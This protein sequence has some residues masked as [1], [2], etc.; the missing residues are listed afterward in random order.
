VRLD[1]QPVL[2]ALAALATDP[3]LSYR[4]RFHAP[5]SLADFAALRAA[6]PE[7]CILA[8]AT[9][10][11]LWVTKQFRDLGELIYLG[12]VAELKTIGAHDGVLSIGAAATLED[13]WQALAA[14]WPHLR[15]VGLR[16]AGPPV[17]H[18]GTMGGNVANGSPIGDSAPVLMALDARIV[19]QRADAV[20][21]MPLADFYVDYMKNR[22]EAGEFVHSLRVPLPRAG[23]QL[24][25][26]K[27]SKRFDCDISA[28]C[29]G[30]AITLDGDTVREARFAYGGMAAIVKRA[31][32]AEA[33]ARG[34][35]WTQQTVNDAVA[36]LAQD[37]TPLT[38]M[39]ASAG[40]RLQVAGNLLRRLWLET[41]P[42]DP[43]PAQAVSVWST[44]AQPAGEVA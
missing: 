23:E 20:R 29:A 22:L 12:E 19:L 32:N 36:A 15:E 8:G 34:R 3:P 40:Y 21:E 25:A 39:R 24:R 44:L 9:D 10:M 6:R 31:V 27:I 37:F 41:R 35:P 33:A 43:L 18:A 42:Q 30:L 38:D 14:R 2:Q 5:R 26:Y 7:A 4:G 11:G 13:A 28:L 16:F 1:P 17:R